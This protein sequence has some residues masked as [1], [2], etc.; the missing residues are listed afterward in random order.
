MHNGAMKLWYRN[1][2]P[3]IIGY[4]TVNSIP[5][6][7][8]GKYT[9][10]SNP[11]AKIEPF[12]VNT[13]TLMQYTA[14]AQSNLGSMVNLVGA[15]DQQMA[16]QAGGGMSATPQ[17]VEAQQAMVDITTNNYQKAIE[18]FVS[19]YCSYALTIYFQELKGVKKITP[20]AEARLKLVNAGAQYEYIDEQGSVHNIILDALDENGVLEIDF[21]ELAVEYFVRC[22]PGSLVEMED[23]KQLRILQELFVPLSQAMPALAATQDRQL[24]SNA[25]ATM[26]F[27]METQIELSGSNR[28]RD[29]HSLLKNGRTEQFQ[30]YETKAQALEDR[31]NGMIDN[32]RAGNEL[33]AQ[34][35][36][37]MQE[38]I[39]L[40]SE[41]QGV[42]LKKLGAPIE[43]SSQP[44]RNESQAP[45]RANESPATV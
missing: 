4:G 30:Q 43:D 15:A 27:I 18:S 26:Q 36:G 5:N 14:I 21:S 3:S 28:S 45:E 8:P 31:I 11:N 38:Q 2:N 12:E 19:K 37:Q 1:I 23:E 40:L 6:L 41:T 20:S 29:L 24:I 10:I 44:Q 39:K 25:V 17:G 33:M 16:T 32:S 34:A 13:G 22:I 9:P 35:L 42:L 7:S